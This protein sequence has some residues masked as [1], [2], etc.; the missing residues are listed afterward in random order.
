[1]EAV[2][3]LAPIE[4]AR[5]EADADLMNLHAAYFRALAKTQKG[6]ERQESSRKGWQLCKELLGLDFATPEQRTKALTTA[7]AVLPEVPGDDADAWLAT[8]FQGDP[9]IGWK[10]IDKVNT[11]ALNLRMRQA[12]PDDRI[13]ALTMIQRL[14]KAI[15]AGAGTLNIQ[16]W[17]S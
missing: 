12:Q 7:L 11:H 10:V 14:G 8:L 4:Q 5:K 13:K 16:T 15:I 3:Y 2:E 9:D 6:T 17:R 1:I